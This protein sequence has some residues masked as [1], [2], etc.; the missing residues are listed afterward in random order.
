MVELAKSQLHVEQRDTSKHRHQQ[1]GQQ[2]GTWAQT[3]G[4]R[5]FGD[6]RWRLSRE[7]GK[8]EKMDEGKSYRLT[9]KSQ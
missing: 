2:K 9:V 1:V 3:Q 8:V 4:R 6:E 7:G 5:D